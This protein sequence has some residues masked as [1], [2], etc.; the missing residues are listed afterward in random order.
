MKKINVR[1]ILSH[2]FTG[3]SVFIIIVSMFLCGHLN[4]APSDNK[5]LFGV[6]FVRIQSQFNGVA[7]YKGFKTIQSP[8]VEDFNL[9]E[10]EVKLKEANTPLNRDSI[11]AL[12]SKL[13]T[14][15]SKEGLKI[16]E[17]RPGNQFGGGN[18]VIPTVSINV[19]TAVGGNDS[20]FALVYLTV[21][22]WY[23]TWSGSQMA[24]SPAIA[25][26]QKKILVSNAKNLVPSVEGA[27][28]ALI[29]EF[30]SSWKSAN[31][32]APE[33][34]KTEEKPKKKKK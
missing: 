29:S 28:D 16:I 2:R 9:L 1:Y 8:Q 20:Y 3:L 30:I 14:V 6:N 22:K 11:R 13:E 23:S 10:V 25:W 32:P 4:A 26:W 34:P 12:Y 33:P 7:Y 15:F 21:D 19:E 31:A 17:V 5:N 27:A 24:Q 18:S